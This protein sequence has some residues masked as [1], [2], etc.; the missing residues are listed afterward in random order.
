MPNIDLYM[1]QLTRMEIKPE[2]LKTALDI[3]EAVP[4]IQTELENPAVAKE[5]KETIIQKIFPQATRAFLLTLAQDGTLGS[6]AEILQ[7]YT[8]KPKEEQ[9]PLICE[10]GRASCRE[11]VSTTV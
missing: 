3:L 10:I 7:D 5:K 6:L 9:K 11:R 2:A 8:R 4:Q 1:E